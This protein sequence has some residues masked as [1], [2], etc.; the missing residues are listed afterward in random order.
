M[1]AVSGGI[2]QLI[3]P[4]MLNGIV[5]FV[6]LNPF[7]AA[8]KKLGLKFARKLGRKESRRCNVFKCSYGF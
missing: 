3:M 1:D 5:D 8:D 2:P 6:L 4:A 7:V